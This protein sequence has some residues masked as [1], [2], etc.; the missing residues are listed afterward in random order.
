MKY[1]E[2]RNEEDWGCPQCGA[3]MYIKI[4][5]GDGFLHD[6]CLGCGFKRKKKKENGQSKVKRQE[7]T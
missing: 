3:M 4:D 1:S 5:V 7:S 2:V 6:V